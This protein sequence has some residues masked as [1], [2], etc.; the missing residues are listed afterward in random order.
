MPAVPEWATRFLS[1]LIERLGR[2][3]KTVVLAGGS[4]PRLGEAALRRARDRVVQP[5]SIGEPDSDRQGAVFVD[6]PTSADPLVFRHLTVGNLGSK[7]VERLGGSLAIGPFLER[8]AKPAR[9]GSR[10][11]AAEEIVE[12]AVVTVLPSEIG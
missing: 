11:S 8:L 3:R 7:P 4:D 2:L 9:D 12:I 10:G 5:V 1:G 6:P